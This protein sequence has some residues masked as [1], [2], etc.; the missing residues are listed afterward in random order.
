MAP[1][2][3]RGNAPVRGVRETLHRQRQPREYLQAEGRRRLV[4]GHLRDRLVTVTEESVGLMPEL[5]E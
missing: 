1:V 4:N 5:S 3:V 2:V